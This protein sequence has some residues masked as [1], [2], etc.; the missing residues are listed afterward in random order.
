GP[1]PLRR[2]LPRCRAARRVPRAAPPPPAQRRRAARGG[3]TRGAGRPVRAA[4]AGPGGPGHR[5]GPFG[6]VRVAAGWPTLEEVTPPRTWCDR[7]RPTGAARCAGPRAEVTT[8]GEEA[9]SVPPRGV[10]LALEAESAA[11]P[12]RCDRG[13][14]AAH[15]AGP[16]T[17]PRRVRCPGR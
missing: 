10:V 3:L 13:M 15:H 4:R 9:G 1:R 17:R 14:A 16:G 5:S 7:L 8:Q 2:G 12:Q 11:A 6:P